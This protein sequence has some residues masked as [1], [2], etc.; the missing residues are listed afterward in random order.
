MFYTE[1]ESNL[2]TIRQSY[3]NTIDELNR[4]IL[5][6]KEQFSTNHQE[7]NGNY[8]DETDHIYAQL[9]AILPVSNEANS[10]DIISHINTLINE[11]NSFK[12]L[13]N[14]KPGL[15][16]K[17]SSIRKFRFRSTN[18]RRKYSITKSMYTIE[19]CQSSMATIF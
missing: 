1:S 10:D 4:E 18:S 13:E 6:L 2:E 15:N 8:P 3:L 14:V 17:I 5:A 16:I 12:D 11:N 7:S 19:Y 9:K